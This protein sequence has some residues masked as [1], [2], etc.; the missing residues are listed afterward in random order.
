MDPTFAHDNLGPIRENIC[1][2]WGQLIFPMTFG[3][4]CDS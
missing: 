2:I 3:S 4:N 1:E